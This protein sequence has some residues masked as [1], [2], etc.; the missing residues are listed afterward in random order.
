[1]GIDPAMVY[2]LLFDLFYYG[3]CIRFPFRI[4]IEDPRESEVRQAVELEARLLCT[5]GDKL[6]VLP[7]AS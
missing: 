2:N 6:A 1:M 4:N 7:W 5:L 3:P